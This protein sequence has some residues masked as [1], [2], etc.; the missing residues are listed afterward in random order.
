MKVRENLWLAGVVICIVVITRLIP[1][2]PNFT[3]LGAAALFGGA[4]LKR[5]YAVMVPVLALFISDLILN[6]LIYAKLLPGFKEGF[7]LFSTQSLWSYG[8]FI[9]I[10]LLAGKLI[11][12]GKMLAIAGSS[13]LASVVFFLISN[14]SVWLGSVIYP[15]TLTGL[16]SAYAAGVPFFWN[17]LAGDLFFVAVLFG[18]FE[19]VK[20]YLPRFAVQSA[21]T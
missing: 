5:S 18:G 4:Y 9:L 1:H 2:Y 6:N 11:R 13:F 20:V 3:A 14:F 21:N 8:A 15:P 17:T 19:A 7:T 10:A 16:L 12:K